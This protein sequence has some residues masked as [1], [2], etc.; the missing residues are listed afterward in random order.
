[1]S[2]NPYEDRLRENFPPRKQKEILK[3]ASII[4]AEVEKLSSSSLAEPAKT[5]REAIKEILS[6]SPKV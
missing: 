2:P 5:A 6:S 3:E 1:M 4:L